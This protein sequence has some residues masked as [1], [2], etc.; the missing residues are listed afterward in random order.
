MV[1]FIFIST[2]LFSHSQ[3]VDLDMQNKGFDNLSQA[4][5]L[6]TVSVEPKDSIFQFFVSGVEAA[7]IDF[8][9]TQVQAEYGLGKNKK[10]VVLKRVKDPETGQTYFTLKKRSQGYKNLNLNIQSGDN[11]DKVKFERLE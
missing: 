6:F 3:T 5:K 8:D 10:T 4:G 9:S 7:E 2:P 11:S 1:T